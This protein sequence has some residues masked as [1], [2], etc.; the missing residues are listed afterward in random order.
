VNRGFS[1]GRIVDEKLAPKRRVDRGRRAS[2]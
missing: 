2:S 1:L